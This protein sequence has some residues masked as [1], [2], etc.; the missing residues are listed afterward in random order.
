VRLLAFALLAALIGDAG[1]QPQQKEEDRR[2]K[3]AAAREEA[4]AR[5]RAIEAEGRAAEEAAVRAA[6]AQQIWPDQQFE[7]WIFQ[8]D[9]NAAGARQRFDAL[10]AL[11]IE[12]I[13]QTCQLTETQKQKLQLTGRGDIKRF[14]DSYEEVKQRFKA[15]NN[16]AERLQEIQPD[17]NPLR[18]ALQAGLFHDDSLLYKS[19]RNTLT[20][21][22][23]TRHDTSVR[24]RRAFRHRANI[25]LAVTTLEQGMPLRDAQRRA[26]ITLLTNETPSPRRSG[27]YD[28]YFVMFQIG[29]VAEAK[30]K[31]LFNDTQWRVVNQQLN[32]FRGM[33]QFLRQNGLLSSEDGDAD[34][35][36]VLP[37]DRKAF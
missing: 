36:E 28:Y 11:Q 5:M 35:I 26:L 33:E 10:L 7:Q 25:E 19:L 22:Q 20:S 17:V 18:M 14:F 30:L 12:D 31:P 6:V 23:F 32:Q 21:E 13:D 8:Q 27:Q 2:A 29:R 34:R 4:L 1:A 15:L 24:E 3:A 16:N 37:V 9:Q